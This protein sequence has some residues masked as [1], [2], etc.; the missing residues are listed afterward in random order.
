MH[1]NHL[2]LTLFALLIACG[3]I[4]AKKQER[5]PMIITAGQSNTDGRVLVHDLPT[6]IVAY[7]KAQNAT[8]PHYKYCQWTYGSGGAIQTR[9]SVTG[10]IF[11]PFWPQMVHPQRP[12]RWA[13]DA[14]VYWNLE[15]TWSKPFYVVKW[16]VGGTAIDPR[17][18]STSRKYWSAS[19]DFLT[20]NQSTLQGGKS[21]LKSFCEEI[22]MAIDQLRREGKTPDIKCMLWHQG[23][24]DYSQGRDYY[25]NLS[26]L[27]N[28]VRQHLVEKTG[29]K[30]YLKLPFIFGTVSTLNKRYNADVDTSMR[31]L[32]ETDADAYLVDMTG[33]ELQRDQLHFTAP[34]AQYLGNEMTKIILALD[35]GKTVQKITAAAPSTN[36]AI[37]TAAGTGTPDAPQICKWQGN[38]HAALTYTF[39]DG[40]QEHYT[41]VLPELKKRGMQGTFCII[42]SRVG[43]DQ[44]GTPCCTWAQLKEMAVSGMEISSHGY[45]HRNVET[46][47]DDEALRY[48]VEHNDT[49][50]YQHLGLYPMTYCYP[51]NRKTERATQFIARNHIGSRMFQHS[52]GAKRD[53]LWLSKWLRNAIR[54]GEWIIGMTHGITT[55]YDCYSD[56]GAMWRQHLDD[57]AQLRDNGELWIATLADVLAYQKEREQT[58]VTT[59]E[60][61]DGIVIKTS[62]P[63]DSAVY[64]VPLT[65]IVRGKQINVKPNDRVILK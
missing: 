39:D 16:S 19:P 41:I 52:L 21:L 5:V 7:G 51:G 30:R 49:L 44:K 40:L 59:E 55:G 33:Q 20:A 15:Q 31:R 35:E 32:A 46:L 62:C 25:A 58:T 48:E 11:K 12:D 57:A 47:T 26:A 42:G 27:I 22:D 29:E 13:Y 1:Y 36:A 56:G 9:D 50:I 61:A 28:H 14:I 45:A 3:A 53:S 43:R 24:S 38:A 18:T 54:K 8:A 23:E 6:D 10:N 4:T 60:T 2:F 37:A 64:S 17:C 63:L 34:S 65:V